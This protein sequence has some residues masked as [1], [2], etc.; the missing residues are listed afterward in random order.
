VYCIHMDKYPARINPIVGESSERSQN[1]DP[2]YL[3]QK[4]QTQQRTCDLCRWKKLTKKYLYLDLSTNLLPEYTSIKI[5]IP[6][7]Y[8][9]QYM[10]TPVMVFG[11]P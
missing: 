9:K 10:I 11:E 5:S 4:S 2:L 1:A 3:L 6:H 7:L 8:L